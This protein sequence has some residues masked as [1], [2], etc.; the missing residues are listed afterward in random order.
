MKGMNK[1]YLKEIIWLYNTS[2]LIKFTGK[3][4]KINMLWMRLIADNCNCLFP[5]SSINGLL[6]R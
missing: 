2:R 1:N 6:K 5:N 3:I 4:I